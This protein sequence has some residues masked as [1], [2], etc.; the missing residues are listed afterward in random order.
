ME[1]SSRKDALP[2]SRQVRIIRINLRYVMNPF[3]HTA[4]QKN[5][6]ISLGTMYT[7][8]F[9]V[10]HK[11]GALHIGYIVQRKR[12]GIHTDLISTKR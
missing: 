5:R 6:R 4:N 1:K 12:F 8:G 11:G 10:L 2:Q 3:L 9:V 7:S